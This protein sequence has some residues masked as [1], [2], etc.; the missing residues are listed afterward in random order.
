MHH[1]YKMLQIGK[2]LL[3]IA[4]QLSHPAIAADLEK[5]IAFFVNDAATVTAGIGL[6]Q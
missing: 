5:K 4:F 1:L 6:K 2:I 3:G